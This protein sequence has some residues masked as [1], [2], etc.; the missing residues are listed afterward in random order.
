M[1]TTSD[2]GIP[3]L[4]SKTVVRRRFIVSLGF[5][6]LV[7]L[8]LL[9]LVGAGTSDTINGAGSS[10]A[11]PVF[12]AAKRAYADQR[13]A[14][15][16]TRAAATGSDWATTGEMVDYEPVG[17]LGG[18]MRLSDPAL[19]FAASDYPLSPAALDAEGLLQ[20][21]L[22][23]GSVAVVYNLDLSGIHLDANTLADIY[24]LRITRWNDPAI[25]AL[26]PGATLP[27][28]AIATVHRSDGSGS[29]YNLTAYLAAG[30]SAWAASRGIG[31]TV[32]WPGGTGAE[33]SSGLIAA[34]AAT[35]GAIGYAETGQAVRAGLEVA[36]MRNG[37]GAFVRPD[38]TSMQAAADAAGWTADDDF[39]RLAAGGGSG[40]G[41]YPITAAVYAVVRRDLASA[42]D[43]NQVLRFLGFLMDQTPEQARD[44]GFL[45]LSDSMRSAVRE[46]WRGHLNFTS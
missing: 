27:D 43:R 44:L 31:S 30:N 39:S 7:G 45:P 24:E 41:A 35:P 29:T 37:S 12:E 25:A 1:L 19:D 36:A 15:D 8:I 2:G 20:F 17:S 23:V 11:Q 42:S 14:D 21:P 32:D 18:I 40:E 38:A 34:V 3:V 9:L 22:I 13:N 33:R 10:L 6:G 16:P 26:N 28:L 4:E 5:F 46:Y